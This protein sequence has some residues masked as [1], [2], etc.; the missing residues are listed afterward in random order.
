MKKVLALLLCMMLTVGTMTTVSFATDGEV[1]EVAT[2]EDLIA[3]AEAVDNGDTFEGRTVKLMADIELENELFEPIGS[4]RNDTA[5]KGIFDGQGHTIRNLSQN[6]W[7][8]DNGYYYGDLGLGLFGLVE[9]ATIKN[10]TIDGAEI[11]GESA[12]CG[13]VAATAFGDC[14]FENITV[15]HA[16]VADYQYYAGGIVG[17]ASGNHQYV[18]CNLDE[19]TT[20]AAQWGDFDNSTGGMIGGCSDSATILM[21]DCTV[22]CRLDVY[23]DVTSSYQWYAYRR[24]G[25]LIGNS[26]QTQTRDGHTSAVAP[27]LTAENVT[28]IYGDWA[29]YHY[30]AF[31]GTSWPYV[32]VEAGISNSAYSNPRY[33][34]PTDA[35]G[36][37][38][39]DDNHVHN[40][41]EDHFIHCDFNQL[42]GGGQ[43]VYGEPAHEGVTVII[44]A[45]AKIG[46]S[47][48]R[49][50]AE[51]IETAEEGDS[52]ELLKTP[53]EKCMP[54][55]L[56]NVEITVA[57]TFDANGGDAVDSIA[58]PY[59]TRLE[60][61]PDP[62][63][64]GYIFTGWYLA[65]SEFD[66]EMVITEPITL[67]A[68][69]RRKP[70]SSAGVNA[71]NQWTEKELAKDEEQ[72][73]YEETVTAVFAD[74]ADYAYYADAVQWA[75]ENQVTAG[76]S[77]RT[78]S[79]NADCTRAQ[80]VTFLWRAA[81][82]PAPTN[83]AMPFADVGHA[84]YYRDAVLWALEN[85]ITEGTD[86]D[87]F[88][89][90][91]QC[92]RAQIVTF[93]WRAQEAENV[94]ANN[95]FTDVAQDAYYTD[96][97]LWA[98]AEAITN[99]TSATTFAPDKTCTRAEVVTFL[100]RCLAE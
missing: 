90:D 86:A 47:L 41:G 48:Y 14:V 15:K 30:C 88:S 6:T 54:H 55:E 43:G 5:F 78:F 65:G 24:C 28:V 7:E 92:T 18:D 22:A 20:I 97:V 10:L 34:H 31:A 29:H 66:T 75:V 82:C 19:T 60:S 17:W 70:V 91:A 21:K 81:G 25:M 68:E 44:P 58:V 38:V 56:E 99:G 26:G 96:A 13:A 16:N 100:Y 45:E 27:Q 73:E 42:Y 63:R 23:N 74:V 83:T 9:D 98:V 46:E 64:K 12:I 72:E 3:F 85:G 79:P 59:G 71:G 49:T 1:F 32:R 4:Y 52:I 51:A 33:G 84:A 69:W 2:K 67:R 50:L 80:V 77:S 95:P 89:P 93:L 40:E 11:S 53:C 39:V 35:A 8:L 76:T 87:A 37:E 62:T 61:L 36:N 57:V 94:T